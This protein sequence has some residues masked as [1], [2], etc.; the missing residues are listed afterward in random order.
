MHVRHARLLP[1]LVVVGLVSALAPPVSGRTLRVMRDGTGDYATI[2]PAIDAASPGDTILIGPGRYAE[3]AP[4]SPSL[5]ALADKRWP[6]ET[7]VGVSVDSLTIRG[8]SRNE[9][10]VGPTE[11]RY[12]AEDQLGIMNQS[13]GKALT[14]RDLTIENVFAG[15]YLYGKIRVENCVVRA[16]DQGVVY[17]S[18]DGMSV[19]QCQFVSNFTGVISYNGATNPTVAN[20]TFLSNIYGIDFVWTSNALVTGCTFTN[21]FIGVQLEQG[22]TGAIRDCHIDSKNGCIIVTSGCAATITNNICTGHQGF[23]VGLD[24]EVAAT[25]NIFRGGD[26]MTIGLCTAPVQIHGNHIL[27]GAGRAVKLRCS[28]GTPLQE[29]DLTNNY[30]GTSSADSLPVWIVDRTDDPSLY[31]FVRFAPISP[32]P[33]PTAKKSLGGVKSLYR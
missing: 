4:F 19:S 29:F 27:K 28:M 12:P 17:W 32:T 3:H 5:P 26:A 33:L 8:A 2:Q 10:I 20:C 7:Y 23:C 14:I 6:A 25:G 18:Q 22:S 30:W 24:G 11:P 31:G 9:V 13:A 16:C 15:C 21:D 1:L